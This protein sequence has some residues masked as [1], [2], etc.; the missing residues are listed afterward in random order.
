MK[1]VTTRDPDY[2]ALRLFVQYLAG[3]T[4]DD[5]V[6]FEKL[7]D[8]H[9][10]LQSRLQR[11]AR[12]RSEAR[13]APRRGRGE[14]CCAS[15]TRR[16]G[17][18]SFRRGRGRRRSP[19]RACKT[20]MILPATCFCRSRA[21]RL[22]VWDRRRPLA[23][24]VLDPG[25]VPEGSEDESKAV[26]RFLEEAQVAGQLDHPG[27][28]PIHDLG[29]DE[30]GRVYFTMPLIEGLDG[31]EVFDLARAELEGW[32]LMRALAVLGKV[33]EAV[34]YAHSRGVIH[35]DLKPANVMVG[36]FGETYVVDWGLARSSARPRPIQSA[37]HRAGKTWLF[38]RTLTE[39][40]SERLRTWPEQARRSRGDAF[41]RCVRAR[42]QLYRL[43]AG[44]S[45]YLQCA[46]TGRRLSSSYAA[47][48]RL[49]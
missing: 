29:A 22:H 3:R 47:V 6:P 30:N 16:G 15:T 18:S 24:K 17:R 27:V 39:A 35:R 49:L 10:E 38:E 44:H 11:L 46:G 36:K 34:A 21:T 8:E 2:R 32:S 12:L 19:V 45:P 41:S 43:L 13:R 33:C 37:K 31:N 23:M 26:A 7:C 4:D 20:A 40:S 48:R 1:N 14:R 9:P 28:V 42:R 5:A 25:T